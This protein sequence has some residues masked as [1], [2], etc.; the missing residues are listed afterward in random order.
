M[1][2]AQQKLRVHCLS[3]PIDGDAAGANQTLDR[4]FGDHFDRLMD[5]LHATRTARRMLGMDSGAT[6]LTY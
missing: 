5:C 4:R 3:T 1:K 2:R 6:G